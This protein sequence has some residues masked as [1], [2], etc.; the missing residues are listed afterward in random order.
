MPSPPDFATILDHNGCNLHVEWGAPRPNGATI[1]FYA[2]QVKTVPAWVDEDGV[3]HR[4]E[5]DGNRSIGSV[6]DIEAGAST[7]SMPSF[8]AASLTD[9]ANGDIID[10]AEAELSS[11]MRRRKA[12]AAGGTFRRQVLESSLLQRSLRSKASTSSADVIVYPSLE[13]PTTEL[14]GSMLREPAPITPLESL[15][16]HHPY[17]WQYS[18][19]VKRPQIEVERRRSPSRRVSHQSHASYVSQQ[20]SA[21]HTTRG[22]QGAQAAAGAHNGDFPSS[23]SAFLSTDSIMPFSPHGSTD[24]LAHGSSIDTQK[25]SSS[26]SELSW[27][28]QFGGAAFGGQQSRMPTAARVSSFRPLGVPDDAIGISS[29]LETTW[30]HPALRSAPTLFIPTG[31]SPSRRPA[32]LSAAGES[33]ALLPSSSS[34]NAAVV[35][36]PRI[37]DLALSSGITSNSI[38]TTMAS[39]RTNATG[40][41]RRA[42][43]P[44]RHAPEPLLPP[45]CRPHSTPGWFNTGD[46]IPSDQ[47]SGTLSDIASERDVFVRCFAW[48]RFG[49]SAASEVSEPYWMPN[50]PSVLK[51]FPRALRITLGSQGAPPFQLQ[52]QIC[53]ADAWNGAPLSWKPPQP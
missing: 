27:R 45:D 46:L 37:S 50:C 19:W 16:V 10:E 4:G 11:P 5:Q 39:S 6:S 13:R 3:V 36:A 38:G 31:T 2:L 47:L 8:L 26:M 17:M 20:S 34:E 44:V 42:E 28:P 23:S 43:S 22:S 51:A 32:Q 30:A 25:S 33:N 1:T 24:S 41:V 53:R 12:A 14:S 18:V 35:Q 29:T 15:D 52:T 40:T 7:L 9:E 21:S 49:W 48:N